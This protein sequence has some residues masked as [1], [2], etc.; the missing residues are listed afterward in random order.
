M[1]MLQWTLNARK[2][3]S[4]MG[5]K[6]FSGMSTWLT[7][8]LKSKET[9]CYCKSQ[10]SILNLHARQGMRDKIE[11]TSSFHSHNEIC[12]Y[13]HHG[14]RRVFKQN[15]GSLFFQRNTMYYHRFQKH[16]VGGRTWPGFWHE[17]I[18]Q[19]KARRER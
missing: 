4:A 18:L 6:L 3:W 11:F 9:K 14:Q 17:A 12:P 7:L 19:I 5:W 13:P 8:T 1:S 15:R 16:L 2:C 10:S